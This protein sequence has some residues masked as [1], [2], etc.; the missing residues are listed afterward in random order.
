VLRLLDDRLGGAHGVTKDKIG[1]VGVLQ[2]H[3]THKQ[4]CG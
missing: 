3:G 2:R 4:R 1:Q